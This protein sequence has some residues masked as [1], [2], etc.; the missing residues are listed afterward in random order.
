MT[1]KKCKSCKKKVKVGDNTGE[2]L[3]CLDWKMDELRK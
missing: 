2:C 1:G 3:K